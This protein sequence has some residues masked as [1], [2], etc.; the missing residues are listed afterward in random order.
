MAVKTNNLIWGIVLTIAGFAIAVVGLRF[1][2]PTSLIIDLIGLGITA[3]GYVVFRA[4]TTAARSRRRI[5]G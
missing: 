2:Y 4:G 1:T 3:F 5:R